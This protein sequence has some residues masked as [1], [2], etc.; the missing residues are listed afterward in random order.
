[1]ANELTFNT[2]SEQSPSDFGAPVA[3]KDELGKIISFGV[4]HTATAQM[5]WTNNADWY[6]AWKDGMVMPNSITVREEQRVTKKMDAATG[7]PEKDPITKKQLYVNVVGEKTMVMV[8]LKTRT[9]LDNEEKNIIWSKLKDNRIRTAVL[10][11]HNKYVAAATKA[12][13][14]IVL[15]DEKKTEL[16]NIMKQYGM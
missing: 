3:K 12:A 13:E 6:Q 14:G 5:V 15:S 2:Y 4:M 1:M 7:L 9:Q 16:D 11:E 10:E 8:G